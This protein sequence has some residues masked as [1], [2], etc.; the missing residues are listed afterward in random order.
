LIILTIEI[1]PATAGKLLLR[2]ERQKEMA[3]TQPKFD[4]AA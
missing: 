1:P 3:R 2:S 4:E